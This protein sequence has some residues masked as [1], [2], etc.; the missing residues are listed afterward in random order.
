MEL[1]ANSLINLGIGM[2]GGIG[3]VAEEEG[4]SHLLTLSMECGPI[5]GIPLGGIDFGA[6]VNPEAMYRMADILQLYDGGAL[7]MAVLGFAEADNTGSVNAHSFSGRTVGA[8]GFI[9]ITQNVKKLCFMGTFTAGKEQDIAIENDGVTIRASGHQK[10]FLNQVEAITFSGPEAVRKGQ[11]VLYI[12]ERAVF[13]L[14]DKGLLLQEIARGADLQKDILDQMEFA[15]I[16]P[17]ELPFM[18]ARLFREG[19]MGLKP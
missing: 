1:K 17:E 13:R 5:G 2:P 19:P 11:Q 8:G 15:P 12:T 9:D 14:T 6:A 16:I 3:S 7:D 18:D 10:K 4:I